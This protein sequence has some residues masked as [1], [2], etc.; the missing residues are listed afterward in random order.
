MGLLPLL[1]SHYSYNLE[2]NTEALLSLSLISV[3]LTLK[4]IKELGIFLWHSVPRV[5]FLP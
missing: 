3:S 2:R 4:E 1:A 5:L